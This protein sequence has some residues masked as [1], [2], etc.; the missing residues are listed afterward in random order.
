[1]LKEISEEVACLTEIQ[2]KFIATDGI[3]SA[4]PERIYGEIV[5]M[6]YLRNNSFVIFCEITK[7]SVRNFF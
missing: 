7:E 4:S 6:I 5:G 1:M 3:G 2:R